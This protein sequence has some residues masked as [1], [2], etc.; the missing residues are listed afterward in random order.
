MDRSETFKPSGPNET[1]GGLFGGS[2]SSG[3]SARNI[4]RGVI[5]A[6]NDGGDNTSKNGGSESTVSAHQNE[7]PSKDN[8]VGGGSVEE[9]KTN[10]PNRDVEKEVG[11]VDQDSNLEEFYCI[12][13]RGDM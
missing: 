10:E 4:G 3:E 7:Y 12:V 8:G 9:H 1:D 13:R 11:E 5:D 6:D 2:E